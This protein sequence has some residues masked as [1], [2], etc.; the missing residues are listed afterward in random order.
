MFVQSATEVTT[1]SHFQTRLSPK[2]PHVCHPL[3][4]II[5]VSTKIAICIHLGAIKHVQ[6]MSHY[7]PLLS[8]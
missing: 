3:V 4:D 2:Y 5:I 6:E 8:R 1:N 7:I